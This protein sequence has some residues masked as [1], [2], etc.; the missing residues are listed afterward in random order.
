MDN[1]EKRIKALADYFDVEESSIKFNEAD[2]TFEL[3]DGRVYLVLTEQEAHDKAAEEVESYL[4][5]EGLGV[6]SE[7]FRDYVISRFVDEDW[8]RDALKESNE[9]YLND[10][11]SESDSIYGNR[12]IAELYDDGFLED[13]DFEEDEDG[14]IDYTTL[15]DSV[16]LDDITEDYVEYLVNREGDPI[17]SYISNFGKDDFYTAV[18]DHNLPDISETVEEAI[19][20]DGVAHFIASYDGD[21]LELEDDYYAYRI[22]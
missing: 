21:E 6:F 11:A 17:E 1:V 10:S 13:A 20:W 2:D 19:D 12:L 7:D 5:V 14:N 18:I 15:K 4:D 22:D 3:E 8:F 16:D 9:Y